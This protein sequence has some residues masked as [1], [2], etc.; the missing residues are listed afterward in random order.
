MV[1]NAEHGDLDQLAR[2]WHD[3]WHESHA[4][5]MPVELTALRT[6]EN[7]RHRLEEALPQIRVVGPPGEPM[8]FSIVRDDELYQLFVS[9]QARGSGVA[10]ALLADAEARLAASGV[11]TAW[12]A[13]AIGNQRAE[14]FY[15]KSGWRRVGTMV[16]QAE[17]SN[18][19]FPL[20]TWRYEKS[21]AP[22]TVL[23]V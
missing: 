2:V 14:R 11:D 13:C 15:E 19:P 5:I 20:K 4:A 3:A 22:P 12:L 16:N 10:A 1:R 9:A 7:F 18:G 6:P 21:L 17:T 23:H 8:G